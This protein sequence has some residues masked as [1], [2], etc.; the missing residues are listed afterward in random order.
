MHVF[1]SLSCETVY[2]NYAFTWFCSVLTLTYVVN[3]FIHCYNVFVMYFYYI[4]S[5]SSYFK[6]FSVFHWCYIMFD[7]LYI[8][9]NG[10]FSS[11]Q[12]LILWLEMVF[13]M[14]E[15][16]YIKTLWNIIKLLNILKHSEKLPNIIKCNNMLSNKVEHQWNIKITHIVSCGISP[17]HMS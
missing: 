10:N 3:S 9:D 17:M 5:L 15:S 8:F 12:V 1:Y 14:N 6:M 16:Y 2:Y 11:V 4:L 7:M 13:D